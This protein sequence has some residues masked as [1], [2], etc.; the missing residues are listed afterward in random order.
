MERRVGGEGVAVG[1][2]GVVLW[3]L[4]VLA[5]RSLHLVSPSSVNTKAWSRSVDG[6]P[7]S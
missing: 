4:V 3:E 7:S 1:G 2:V 6:L 5:E